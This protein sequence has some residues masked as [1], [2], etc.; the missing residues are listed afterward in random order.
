MD[1]LLRFWDDK[2][3][4]VSTRYLKSEF[5]GR[6]TA[7]VLQTILSG[8]SD[9]HKSKILQ[10]PS[11]GPN[12]NLLFLDKLNEQRKEEELDALIDIGTCGLHTIHGSLKAGAKVSG[13]ELNLLKAMWQFL[14]DSPTRRATY[15][16]ITETLD[17]LLQFCGHRWC[18]NETCARKAQSLLVGYKKF[19]TYINSLKKSKQP[20]PKNKSSQRLKTIIHD[21]VL[22]AKLNIFKMVSEKLN[23]FLRHFQTDKP[24]ASYMT[25]ILGYIVHDLFS[26]IILKDVLQKFG[27]LYQQLE[28]D[29]TDENIRKARR[30]CCSVKTRPSKYEFYL[31][32]SIYIQER[33]RGVFSR[34]VVT[35]P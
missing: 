25:T 29:A 22:P 5:M 23:A 14:Y 27:T 35:L 2:A 12:V 24:M 32:K 10:V 1:L 4:M 17:Y 26:R 11:D 31:P 15:E 19:V 16:N 7:D 33:V 6:S 21:S 30:F 28:I 18:E 3:D 8:I 13:W 34:S 9:I 20:D